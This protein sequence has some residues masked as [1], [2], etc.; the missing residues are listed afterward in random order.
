MQ[1]LNFHMFRIGLLPGVFQNILW[2]Q[3]ESF[4]IYSGRAKSLSKYTLGTSMHHLT[5]SWH[6]LTVFL[7]PS[8][9]F[10]TPFNTFLVTCLF[11]R[12][13]E[14]RLVPA[15]FLTAQFLQKT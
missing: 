6:H 15:G 2:V 7:T 5:P 13:E 14:S 9:T 10:P 11:T 1:L 12:L 3:E 4:K 8:D